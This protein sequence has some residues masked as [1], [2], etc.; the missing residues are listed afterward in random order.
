MVLKPRKGASVQIVFIYAAVTL[1]GAPSQR[2]SINDW[3][4]NSTV[5]GP[6]TPI[7]P[8]SNWFGALCVETCSGE[9]EYWKES[10]VAA[11]KNQVDST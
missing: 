4:G 1:Y 5:A 3:I 7:R 8:K 6:T 11:A 10:V 9:L 2:A